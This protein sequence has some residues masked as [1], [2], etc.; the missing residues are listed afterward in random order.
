MAE[1]I[2]VLGLLASASQLIEYSAVVI[3]RL[4]DFMTNVKELPSSFIHINNQLPILI[5]IVN[6]LR[7]R[8]SSGDFTLQTEH[9]LKRVIDGLDKE[10]KGL[11]AVLCKTLPSARAS[12]W[13]KGV[14]A[15]KS[16][17]AQKSVDNFASV[18]QDYVTSLNA[19]QIAHNSDQI[20]TLITS[21]DEQ[22]RQRQSSNPRPVRK[23][24]WMLEYDSEEDFVGRDEIM[25]AMEQRFA[26]MANRVVITGIGGVGY[27]DCTPA[28]FEFLYI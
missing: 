9:D 12:T 1:A 7:R 22:H 24:I 13:E 23:P 3:K 11:D 27:E 2:V 4:H 17:A 10:L 26:A 28:G 14:K 21:I 25:K 15:V 8:V 18:I 20:K 6:S 5:S 19:F 16:V